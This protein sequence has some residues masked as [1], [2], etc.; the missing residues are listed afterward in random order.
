MTNAAS[1]ITMQTTSQSTI[2]AFEAT[3]GKAAD[4]LSSIQAFCGQNSFLYIVANQINTEFTAQVLAYPTCLA[5]LQAVNW[6]DLLS[7]EDA[8]AAR[9]LMFNP[10]NPEFATNLPHNTLNTCISEI[11]F[12]V[13]TP[14]EA[15]YSAIHI[16]ITRAYIPSQYIVQTS[17]MPNISSPVY[18]A[19]AA[20][21]LQSTRMYLAAAQSSI[22][23]NVLVVDGLRARYAAAED[24]YGESADKF[25]NIDIVKAST[26]LQEL[27]TSLPSV[28]D[29]TTGFQSKVSK[30]IADAVAYILRS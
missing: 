2:S 27:T 25:L 16:A 22:N 12:T 19:A 29:A 23:Q 6:D 5:N 18:F 9:N 10:V 24:L 7:P 21:T 11:N 4:V 14:D 15:L 20:Q 1:P 30:T 28:I 13:K 26:E 3:V 17:N 8:L